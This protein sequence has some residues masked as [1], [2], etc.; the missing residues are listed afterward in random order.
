METKF[1]IFEILQ[2]AEQVEHKGAKF[3]LKTSELF[4]DPAVRDIYYR[5]AT[6]KAKH[7][8][9]WARMRKRFSEK[10]G[11][12]GTFDPDNY[13]LSN[14]QVMSGLT[15]FGTKQEGVNRLTGR[16]S[17]RQV[18][19]DAIRRANEVIIFYRGLKDFARDPATRQM[20]D[21]IIREE[22][23]QIGF[24]MDEMKSASV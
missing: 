15:W 8:K 7:E 16:E 5:L 2:I 19:K 4:D 22:D 23:R 21:Q 18:L 24:L 6:W 12:F 3:F 17:K 10:T 20:I 1:N 11:E 14:P 13:V 9:I